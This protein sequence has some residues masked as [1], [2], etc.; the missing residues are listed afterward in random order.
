MQ[1]FIEASHTILEMIILHLPSP[2]IAQQYR[3]S[4]LYK[5]PKDDVF[6]KAMRNCDSN[7]PIMIYIS[8]MVPSPDKGRFYAFGRIFSGKISAGTKVRILGPNFEFGS[9][10]DMHEK[11]VSLTLVAMGRKM[12]TISE[13]YCGNTISL[14]GL[15][16]YLIKT[17][18][19]CS[20]DVPDCHG[21]ID[22]KYSVSP[23]VRVAV[24]PK[25]PG[26][27]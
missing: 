2:K 11:N 3:Y 20:A 21:I 25:N 15:D 12:E 8:K 16:Q 19:I 14:S 5:G 22:M 18:T 4:Y 13:V 1:K 23:V 10:H 7:G 24:K 9:K 27:L 17:G 6:A 26:D